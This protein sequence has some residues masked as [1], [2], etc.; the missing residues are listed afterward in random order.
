VASSI[1]QRSVTFDVIS[2]LS[3]EASDQH[4]SRSFGDKLIKRTQKIVALSVICDYLQ[5]QAYSFPTGHNRRNPLHRSGRVRR[6]LIRI[7]SSTTFGYSSGVPAED[8]QQ[9]AAGYRAEPGAWPG[10]SLMCRVYELWV[11]CWAARCTTDSPG[12]A[13]EAAVRVAG[14]PEGD[15]TRWTHM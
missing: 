10:Y 7:P 14:L 3:L 13:A 1:N 12:T 9:F 2:D 4:P 5:H 15:P 8:F 6:P 11:A